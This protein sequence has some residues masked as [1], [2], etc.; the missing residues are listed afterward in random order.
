MKS[1]ELRHYLEEDI[2][3]ESEAIKE[4]NRQYK[5][6]FIDLINKLKEKLT[7][8]LS[9]TLEVFGSFRTELCLQ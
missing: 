2:R 4:E 8:P 3:L 9:I 6:Y 5:S 1:E 7:T